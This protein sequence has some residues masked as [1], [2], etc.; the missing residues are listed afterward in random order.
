MT[1]TLT[2][3]FTSPMIRTFIP[4]WRNGLAAQ[5]SLNLKIRKSHTFKFLT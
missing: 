3:R 5:H 1:V 4:H 2:R